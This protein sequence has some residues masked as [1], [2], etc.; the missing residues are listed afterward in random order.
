M[1]L[2]PRQRRVPAVG[3]L[4]LLCEGTL[5][6]AAPVARVAA[7][8]PCTADGECT[9]DEGTI[10]DLSMLGRVQRVGGTYNAGSG[11]RPDTFTYVFRLYANL[12]VLPDICE[13]SGVLSASAMRY[14]P[15]QRFPGG[16]PPSCTVIGPDM[17]ASPVYTLRRVPMGLTFSYQLDNGDSLEIS[18]RCREGAGVGLPADAF[19]R[20]PGQYSILWNNGISCPGVTPPCTPGGECIDD[21]GQTWELGGPGGGL[22]QIQRIS[23]PVLGQTYSFRLYSNLNVVPDVCS[24]AGITA[25]SAMRH[26]GQGGTDPGGDCVQLGPDMDLEPSYTVRR[27]PTGLLFQYE[28]DGVAT[29][30]VNLICREV[31]THLPMLRR[32]SITAALF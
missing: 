6:A 28:L 12:A 7:D 21:T 13:S 17:A 19:W 29:I 8:A 14:D 26:E 9:D 25:S 27:V 32:P 15:I 11:P 3:L 10:W 18:L 16:P 30:R 22:G 24:A 5:A 1:V 4:L 31:R 2:Q 20:T 23:G